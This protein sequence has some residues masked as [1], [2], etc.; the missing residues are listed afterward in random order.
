MSRSANGA[1]QARELLAALV[2]ARSPNPPGDERAVAA[3]IER[4]AQRLGLPA[5]E[6]HAPRP[7]RPNLLLNLGQGRPRLIIAAHM[8][9]MPPGPSGAWDG[10]PYELQER[11]D[12]LVGLGTADMKAS[13]AVMLLAAARL[14]A[15]LPQS[16]TVTLAFTA[17]EENGSAEGMAW[18]CDNGLIDGDAAVMTEPS[19]VSSMSWDAL[20]VAQRGSCVARLV[21]R[22][23]AGHSGESVDPD[24]RA[25]TAFARALHA[26]VN[27]DTFVELSH[28]VDGTRPLVNVAT[29]VRGGEVPFAH[30]AQLEAIVE[31]RTISGMSEA[32]VL[33]RLRTVLA[34]LALDGR[35]DFEPGPAP[36]W[37]P[38]GETVVDE[39]LL[40]AARAAW[41][42]VLGAPPR[43]AVFPAGTDSSHLDSLGIPALPAF[44][45]GT[46]GVV[47]RPNE[48]VLSHD[49]SKAID[50]VERLVHQFFAEAPR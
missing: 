41:T 47:H 30:P 12:R 34:P 50:L 18:L 40:G 6:C 49:L 31:V 28:P 39:R 48:F 5:P 36:S 24:E 3:V 21:A 20:Y 29:M 42:E 8:D 45:P 43:E 44:G 26:L 33:G 16:G 7:E 10:D 13:I 25:G 35:V 23:R 1:A 2:A 19:S 15:E 38:P 32:E 4:A 11:G 27:S 22:G 17:D 37:I 46:L 14:V 9:T